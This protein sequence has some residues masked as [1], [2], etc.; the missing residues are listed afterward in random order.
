MGIGVSIFTI[1]LGAILKF[2]ISPTA[3]KDPV[4]VH[5]IG[6]ILMIV[7]GVSVALQLLLMSRPAGKRRGGDREQL[8]N[9]DNPPSV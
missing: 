8:Y 9:N 2:A 5:V 4:N 7:G 6:V 1:T 3:M